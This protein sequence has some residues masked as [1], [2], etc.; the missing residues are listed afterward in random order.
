MP[1][2]LHKILLHGAGVIQIME[3]DKLKVIF[4]SKQIGNAS[5]SK[6]LLFITKKAILSVISRL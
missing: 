5:F 3:V 6:I 2:S 4:H 1:N